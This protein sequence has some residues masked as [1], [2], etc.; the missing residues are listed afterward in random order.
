MD[1]SQAMFEQV[2]KFKKATVFLGEIT[3][4]DG[5]SEVHFFGTGSLVSIQN[6]FHLVTAKHII[7]GFQKAKPDGD[8][9]VFLN[10]KA[11][12]IK[13]VSINELR[14]KLN[15]DWMFHENKVVDVAIIPIELDIQGDDIAVIP[16]SAFEATDKIFELT[17]VFY[18]SLQPGIISPGRINPII[19]QGMVSIINDDKTFYIDGFAFPGNSGSPCFLKFSPLFYDKNGPGFFTP[20]T[21]NGFKFLGIIG[22]FLTSKDV[23]VSQQT[24][25]PRVIF[26]DNTG[27]SR[28]WSVNFLREIIDSQVFRNQIQQIQDIIK[29]RATAKN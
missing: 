10:T 6:I 18:L 27:L 20:D 7:E 25:R 8:I 23:A 21:N 29:N 22:E 28:V 3:D 15:V 26:E 14:K 19:R 13:A 12:K 5:K 17:D 16:E 1:R 24:G 11:G 9:K 2:S 4:K